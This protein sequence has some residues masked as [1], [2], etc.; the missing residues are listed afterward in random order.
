MKIKPSGL[1]LILVFA[2]FVPVMH[3]TNPES[4]PIVSKSSGTFKSTIPTNNVFGYEYLGFLVQFKEKI[5]PLEEFQNFIK[6]KYSFLPVILI[7]FPSKS[8]TDRFLS[9]CE[10][11]IVSVLPNRAYRA[12]PSLYQSRFRDYLPKLKQ[13]K[14]VS[15]IRDSTGTTYLHQ[16]NLTGK[17]VR[18]GII[19]TGVNSIGEIGSR[20]IDREVFVSKQFG[21][22]NDISDSS[23]VWG[24]G[25]N[26]ATF[27]AGDSSGIAP[28]AEILSAK[29]IHNAGTLGAGGGGGEETT[30]GMLAA[31]EWLVNQ[32]ADIINISLGQYHNLPTGL[33][34]RVINQI[35]IDHNI[36]FTISAGNSG[37]GF[38]DR[39]TLN[40]PSTA[41]QAIAV[42]ASDIDGTFVASFASKG[43]KVD[44]SM[45]PDIAAPGVNLPDQGTSFAAPIV[46]GSAALLIEGLRNLSLSYSA[47]TIKAA[48]L[49]GAR[50]MGFP[51]WKEGAG[52]LN[53]TNAW[54]KLRSAPIENNRPD[55]VYL[56]PKQL[57]FDPY[58]VLFK[59]SSITL[60]L[61]VISGLEKKIQDAV[62]SPSLAPYISLPEA[63]VDINN[64]FLLPIN[65]TIPLGAEEQ[66]VQGNLTI[67]TERIPVI[68]EIRSPQARILFDESLNSIVQHGIGTTAEE[69]K[70]DTSST[71]G[72][73]AEFT[74]FL[75]YDNNYSVIPH[76]K[77]DLTLSKLSKFD[78]LI[79]PA[80]FSLASDIYMDWVNN[81]G[82]S[83]LVT[84]QET[85]DAVHQFVSEGGGLLVLST[86]QENYN[87]TALNDFLTPFNIQIQSSSSGIV[88]DAIIIDNSFNFTQN[89]DSYPHWGNYLL[90]I[91]NS[92]NERVLATSN[93]EPTLI[94]HLNPSGGRVV[95]FGSDLLFDNIGFSLAAYGNQESNRIF[96]FNTVAWL[97]QKSLRPTTTDLPE[98]PLPL[99][100]FLLF[101]A[102]A[103]CYIIY[104]KKINT[105]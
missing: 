46:A 58:E 86:D 40:N 35:S 56:H 105:S 27:A 59:G 23:D 17:G 28:D 25:T 64:S 8:M 22:S 37:T 14:I 20:V 82:N 53:V 39:G 51:S 89:V 2:F 71:I 85:I 3:F 10:E 76:I 13:Q 91:G 30:A 96:A 50:S 48:L 102:I 104:T 94:A 52:F 69:V 93:G 11:K 80:P 78:V 60:N 90:K 103:I 65:F 98:F 95:V 101:S 63:P 4:Q 66:L 100:I 44:Y 49:D 77:G 57:P 9:S 73:F 67:G 79:L 54:E 88:A 68:F 43:P 87:L 32:S 97:S 21:Y 34:D 26:V 12:E 72:M 55:L 92:S 47:S 19:D 15:T 16:M 74:R 42:T 29:V 62:L 99:V 18:I 31:I 33:R 41:L 81:P 1:L 7:E 24:H 75:A 84:S 38:G 6:H 61:T 36:V 83:Y 45:K 5:P 70:G